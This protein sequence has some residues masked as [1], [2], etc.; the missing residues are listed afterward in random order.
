MAENLID[1]HGG[2]ISEMMNLSFEPRIIKKVA[3]YLVQIFKT[4]S[5]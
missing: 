5:L 4:K 1:L 2:K 3:S